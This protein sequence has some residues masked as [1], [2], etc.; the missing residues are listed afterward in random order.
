MKPQIYKVGSAWVL[1]V[2]GVRVYRFSTWEGALKH[3]L[4][5]A[6]TDPARVPLRVSN[7]PL[8]ESPGIGYNSI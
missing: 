2:P 3:A 5:P 4:A 1:W 6:S 7:P 8:G